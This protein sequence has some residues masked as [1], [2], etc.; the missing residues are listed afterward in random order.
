MVE[1]LFLIVLKF[2]FKLFKIFLCENQ[3]HISSVLAN[4]KLKF[5]FNNDQNTFKKIIT[6]ARRKLRRIT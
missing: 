2:F 6:K 5:L 3:P 4:Y 1:Y